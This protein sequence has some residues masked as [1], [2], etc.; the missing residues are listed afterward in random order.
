MQ[1]PQ[2][3]AS[4]KT[5]ADYLE[6]LLIRAKE[7]TEADS[8]SKLKTVRDLLYAYSDYSP[9]GA[10]LLDLQANAAA[11]DLY[12]SDRGRRLDRLKDRDKEFA[13]IYALIVAA[14]SNSN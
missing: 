3:T 2:R 4:M 9:K 13:N 11:V 1:R 12:E 14:T 10:T 8:V 6:S 5:W 7:A